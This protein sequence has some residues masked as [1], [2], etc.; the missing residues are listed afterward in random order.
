MISF[1]EGPHEDEPLFSLLARIYDRLVGP[2]RAQ[3]AKHV[4]GN[5]RTVIPF[6]FPCGIAA[7][8]KSIG[9]QIG[10]SEE[11]LIQKHTMFPIAAFLMSAEKAE[12]VKVAMRGDRAVAMNLIKWHRKRAQDGLRH[13]YFCSKCRERDLRHVGHTWWRRTHQVPGVICCPIHATSL[14]ISQFVIGQFWKLDYPVADT[15]KSVRQ[16]PPPDGIDI[17]YAR[18]VRWMLNNPPTP[19][20][21]EKL[22]RLYHEKAEGRGLL[23]SGQLQRAEFLRRFYEQR[24]KDEWAHRQLLFNPAN[25][26]A[27]PAQTLKNKANH[28]A[29]QMH[30][31]V[32]R[33]LN[34][35]ISSLHS[36]LAGMPE[37]EPDDVR[38]NETFLRTQLRDRWFD[39]SWTQRAIMLD[40]RIGMVRLLSLANKEGLP[41][42][43]SF[44]PTRHKKF[45]R[46]RERY[47][48]LISSGS[49]HERS[50]K[51][52]AA[53]RWLGRN[54]QPW[55]RELLK[56][57]RR[58]TVSV[59]D[60]SE[61][62]E[63]FI[64]KLPQL[65]SRIQ[66]ERPF[67]RVCTASFVALLPFGASMGTHLREKMP[68]LA[69]EMRR[70]TETTT[71]FTLRRI[72]VIRQLHP[73]LRPF[74]VRERAS[75]TKNYRYPEL[76]KAMGY[77]LVGSRWK[78][79]EGTPHTLYGLAAAIGPSL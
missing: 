71:E 55:L 54:D 7:L 1:I 44:N 11:E 21:P 2:S 36:R 76:F 47:R 13:L 23:R 42:P 19:I 51:W 79:P 6:D 8:T 45:H 24:T 61:R 30:L 15:A 56:K 4:F 74:E 72:K 63:D 32:M 46:N 48:K 60:W 53:M 5:P 70:L 27:W 10:L 34:L 20:D 77:V 66:A 14:E 33:F 43:R 18:D 22:R 78:C 69:D 12:C 49:S 16:T 39:T 31:L 40:L 3:F 57:K 75:V 62:Q 35:S 28:K 73:H 9:S 25:P 17:T 41:I 64:R 50:R 65:A 29:V 68:R 59:V 58:K 38:Q 26:S 37:H 67:R 52:N